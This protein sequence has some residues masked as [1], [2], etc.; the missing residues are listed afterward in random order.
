MTAATQPAVL[1]ETHGAV[2]TVTLNRP[3]KRNA[4]DLQMRVVLAE[5]IE[6]AAADDTIRVIVIIGAGPAF[7]SGGDISTM[8]RLL[9]GQALDRV[10]DG[11]EGDSGDLDR[12]QPVLAAVEG[13]AYGA[14]TALAAACDRVVAAQDA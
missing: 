14:G 3:D 6:A 8:K 4:I 10:P 11:A 13:S 12:P 1:A 5:A 9:P 2:C 7:C